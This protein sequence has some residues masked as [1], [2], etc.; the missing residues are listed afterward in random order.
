[1]DRF[2]QKHAV[3]GFPLAVIYKFFDDQGGYLAALITYY[4]FLSVFPLLLL[5]ASVLGFILQDNPE[6]Q[7]EI[8]DSALR[9][10]PVIGD[11]LGD[12]QGLRGSTTAVAI[13][14]V[15]SLYG[16]LGVANATQNAMN[17]MWA[18]PRNRRPN[19]IAAR[20][21]SLFLLAVG[22]L[23]FVI[24]GSLGGIGTNVNGFAD[25][26]NFNEILRLVAGLAGIT[27]ITVFFMFL[28]RWGTTR[29]L[30]RMDVLPGAIG[31]AL[32]WQGLQQFGTVYVGSVV[33]HADATNG[34]FAIVLG[35]IAWIYLAVV[36]LLIC[37]EA[38]VVRVRHLYPRTLLTP[39]TD[40]V[41]LTEA[42][43]RAYRSYARAQRTKDFEWVDVGFEHGGQNATA[44]RKRRLARAQAKAAL[45]A[46][47]AQESP[48]VREA[49][50]APGAQTV[51]GEVT[52][53]PR[54]PA[55]LPPGEEATEPGG[56]AGPGPDEGATGRRGRAVPE[57]RPAGDSRTAPD[58]IAQ[59]E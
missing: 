17:T 35:L 4:G 46:Q 24:T 16:A 15:G 29:R 11:Q 21:R 26:I 32:V 22:G 28:F 53:G 40:D 49:R 44:R 19:P 1:M 38:N 36:A 30:S 27:L 9:Q 43:Q 54:P 23:T 59:N 45:R 57:A 50:Q 18:V 37:A 39:F 12:P 10:F 42:D 8:L 41:D 13:G 55:A 34:V 2:Q 51:P 47:E 6:L 33:R 20:L 3:I 52:G 58:G 31:A 7:Q 48:A 5:L 25:L 56:A 14:L